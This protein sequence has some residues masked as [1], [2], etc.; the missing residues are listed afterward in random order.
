M[1]KTIIDVRMLNYA[2]LSLDTLS[3]AGI[4][5]TDASELIAQFHKVF[6]QVAEWVA[7]ITKG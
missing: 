3:A 4:S 2:T 5:Q 7:D 1:D 6:P